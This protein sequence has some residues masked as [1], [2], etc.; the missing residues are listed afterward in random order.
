MFLFSTGIN[1]QNCY[2]HYNFNPGVNYTVSFSPDTSFSPNNYHL[3]WNFGDGTSSS[4]Y[5]PT[6]VF[7]SPPPYIVCYDILDNSNTIICSS[8]DTVNAQVIPGCSF[9][10]LINPG[11]SVVFQTPFTAVNDVY[12]SV[13]DSNATVISGTPATFVYS[14]EGTY[15]VCMMIVNSSNHD[16]L[17]YTCQTV[18]VSSSSGNCSFD[19]VNNSG[20]NFSYNFSANVTAGSTVTW[21]FG[22]STT[23]TGIH[24]THVFNDIGHYTVCINVTEP[25]NTVCHYCNIV[26]VGSSHGNCNFNAGETSIPKTL[27]FAVL[28][29]NAFPNHPIA[30][31]FGDGSV[32]YG[33]SAIHTYTHT[34]NY[35]VCM[36][37]YNSDS[38]LV[39]CS[40]C[41]PVLI[42]SS[43][44]CNFT[45]AVHPNSSSNLIIDFETISDPGSVVTWDFGDSTTATG[46]TVQHTYA[47]PG[48]Y[49][50]C[51]SISLSGTINCTACNLI[52]V[53]NSGSC[54]ISYFPDSTQNNY[55]SFSF[56][57]SSSSNYVSWEFG[58]GG[59][60]TGL[61]VNHH[62]IN[63]GVYQV[64]GI[65][66]DYLGNI[67]C[68]TCVSVFVSVGSSICH[69]SY[70]ATSLG[71]TAYFINLSISNSFPTSYYWDFGDGNS[72][73]SQFPHHTYAMPGTYNT[74][75]TIASQNCVNQF[76]SPVIVDTTIIN[77]GSGCQAFYAFVQLASFEVTIVNLSSGI[78]LNFL[79]D[80]G[81]GSTDTHPF[82]SHVYSTTGTYTLCLTVSDSTGC[83]S[84]FCDTLSV[85]SLGNLHR[86]LAGFTLNVVSTSTLT[87]VKELKADNTFR[88]F[89]N[90]VTSELNISIASKSEKSTGYRL[91]SLLGSEVLIGKMNGSDEKINIQKINSGSYLL[92]LT[93]P[94]GSRIYKTIVKN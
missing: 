44:N 87:G 26:S 21:D 11:L 57:P 71:L 50:V 6:H 68:H 13:G 86:A 8:C 79:W 90:P 12:W 81:D 33:D 92:E 73:T 40:A 60:D 30:W 9:T 84:T 42:S 32:G 35:V 5:A 91:L 48:N 29:A 64:C 1:A 15:N 43:N 14:H 37:Q 20:S 36:T 39:L 59:L 94:D 54:N 7:N 18:T 70:L 16:T 58:D 55:Y 41:N 17:C 72:S 66:K 53:G 85:D 49:H 76:C 93:F 4:L 80:F 31:D 67:I 23:A 10:T 45:T 74:C 25:N 89:P 22:D 62:F 88:A 3:T 28:N 78:N 83:T 27:L 47:N 52:T 24:T 69:A 63:S 46:N 38:L 19:A 51:V 2:F 77:P 56:L 65:E 82:P 34:G 61:Y 75:L